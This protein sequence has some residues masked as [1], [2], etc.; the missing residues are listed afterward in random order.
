MFLFLIILFKNYSKLECW[1]LFSIITLH[2]L[3]YLFHPSNFILNYHLINLF[4]S[5]I[6]IKLL[7]NLIFYMDHNIQWL[8]LVPFL[9]YTC[10]FKLKQINQYLNR[11][12]LEFKIYLFHYLM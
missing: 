6:L 8:Q 9:I 5:N 10:I 12:I 3:F 1:D 7:L 2:I 11:M 4:H